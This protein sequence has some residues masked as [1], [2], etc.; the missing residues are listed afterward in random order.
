MAVGFKVGF[1]WY[2]IGSGDFLHCFFSTVAVNLENNSWGS[3]FP[4]IMNQLYQGS[5]ESENVSKALIEL[6]TIKEE[7][8]IISPNKVIW[9][10][11]DNKKLQ[12]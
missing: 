4:L 1:L 2:Q 5:L 10:I 6:N 11:D 3:R 9:D 12:P 8:R 7:I